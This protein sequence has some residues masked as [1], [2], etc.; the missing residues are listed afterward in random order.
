MVHIGEVFLTSV[1]TRFKAVKSLGDRAMAQLDDGD[2]HWS[3]GPEINSI[4]VIVRHMHGN[5]LSRWTDFL[6]MDGEKPWRE[7]NGEFD[8]NKR[9][10]RDALL[11]LWDEGWRSVF[12]AIE[13]LKP[14]DL[15]EAITIRGEAM[16]A[17]DA[18]ERQLA[19]YGYHVGQI[20]YIAR[21]RRGAEWHTLSIA[22]GASKSYKPTKQD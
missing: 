14:P 19:H 1:L 21:M 9:E 11:L 2:L 20:V 16:P 15:L 13:A 17:L 3:P 8:E 12:D 7:R 6:T 18:I 10:S 4:A 22:R 5:M